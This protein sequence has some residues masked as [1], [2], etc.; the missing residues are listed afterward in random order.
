MDVRLS[1]AS[2][3]AKILEIGSMPRLKALTA[4]VPVR[5]QRVEACCSPLGFPLR[6]PCA[7]PCPRAGRDR[8]QRSTPRAESAAVFRHARAMGLEGIV[9]RRLTAVYRLGRQDRAQRPFQIANERPSA[10]RTTATYTDRASKREISQ[11][12]PGARQSKRT[13]AP[14]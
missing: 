3:Q 8:A 10:L 13:F 11:V 14:S 2:G 4:M 7:A 6:T 9:S 1:S 5:E 12:G